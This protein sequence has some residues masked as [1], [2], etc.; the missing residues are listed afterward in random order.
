MQH[1]DSTKIEEDMTVVRLKKGN[2][3][4]LLYINYMRDIQG[5]EWGGGGE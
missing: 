4:L 5:G 3:R 2:F 1:Y